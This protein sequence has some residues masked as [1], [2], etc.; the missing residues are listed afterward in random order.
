MDPQTEFP[1]LAHDIAKL[2][3][4]HAADVAASATAAVAATVAASR[5]ERLDAER[6]L[7]AN[8]QNRAAVWTFDD[9]C[10]NPWMR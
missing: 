10:W 7:A 8:G 4:K 3:S 6:I 1:E 2:N 5:Q 9:G